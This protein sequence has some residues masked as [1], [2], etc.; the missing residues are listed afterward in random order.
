MIYSMSTAWLYAFSPTGDEQA[1][2]HYTVF[3]SGPREPA[4]N[5]QSVLAQTSLSYLA[6]LSGNGAGAAVHSYTPPFGPDAEFNDF[7]Y[8]S[9]WIDD[10]MAVTFALNAVGAEAYS[11][12]T[13][14]VFD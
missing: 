10:C 11:L 5:G 7:K 2:T 13:I 12:A 1:D 3:V 14:F 6:T 8:N 9:M 4:I